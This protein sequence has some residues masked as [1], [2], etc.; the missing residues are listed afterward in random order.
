MQIKRNNINIYEQGKDIKS[1]IR[2]AAKM[3]KLLEHIAYYS[4]VIDFAITVVTLISLNMHKA[5]SSILFYLNIALSA[6]VVIAAVI[7]VTI[8][9]LSHYDKIIDRFAMINTHAPKRRR[10][11]I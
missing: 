7:F 9:F 4:L 6:T 8:F 3:Q 10:K 2:R 1:N 11:R 5:L